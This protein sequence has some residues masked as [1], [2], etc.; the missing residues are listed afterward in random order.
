MIG[1]DINKNKEINNDI[2]TIDIDVKQYLIHISQETF[3]SHAHCTPL[4]IAT[5][6]LLEGTTI[7]IIALFQ[8]KRKVRSDIS[9]QRSHTSNSS[10]HQGSSRP[11]TDRYVI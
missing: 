4:A 5:S 2:S 1:C 6:Q 7:I 11:K 3:P 10:P 9:M 8:S